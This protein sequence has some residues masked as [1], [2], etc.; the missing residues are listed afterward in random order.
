MLR[1]PMMLVLALGSSLALGCDTEPADLGS[2]ASAFR[3]AEADLM[4][5]LNDYGVST[6]SVLD[7]EC[8]IRSDAAQNIDLY[9]RG[10]DGVYGTGDDRTIDSEVELD[11]IY[12][13]GPATIT[14]L[15]TCAEEFGYPGGSCDPE[16][17][18]V[19]TLYEYDDPAVPSALISEIES[20][21][22]LD[23]LCAGMGGPWESS[24]AELEITYDGCGTATEYEVTW[25][26]LVDEEGV[27]ELLT[28]TYDAELNLVNDGCDVG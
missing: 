23:D 5:F 4:A 15:Y 27:L 18:W 22:G 11:S 6:Q 28:H 3:I 20:Y 13:V 7:F 9:R 14:L 16:D 26:R 17:G 8:A 24:F 19:D 12:R 2:D 25:V 10:T 1:T 21:E